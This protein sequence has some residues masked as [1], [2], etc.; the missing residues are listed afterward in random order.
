MPTSIWNPY[1]F[2]KSFWSILYL[3]KKTT[4]QSL[5]KK[6]L[7]RKIENSAIE[8][9]VALWVVLSAS[10]GPVIAL[11]THITSIANKDRACVQIARLVSISSTVYVAKQSN[12]KS[13]KWRLCSDSNHLHRIRDYRVKHWSNWGKPP[14][15]TTSTNMKP[16]LH[17]YHKSSDGLSLISIQLWCI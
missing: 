4:T 14:T 17:S 1:P 2:L 7:I 3:G 10:G 16:L 12:T 6:I 15:H 11:T 5:R 13:V 9:V 8:S